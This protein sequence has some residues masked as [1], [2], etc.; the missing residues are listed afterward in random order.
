MSEEQKDAIYAAYLGI[1]VL[2]TMFRRVGLT[3]GQQRS[4][5]LLTELSDTFPWLAER[6]ALSALRSADG[7]KK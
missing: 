7:D 3:L 1:C 5:D 4:A 6:V 2:K